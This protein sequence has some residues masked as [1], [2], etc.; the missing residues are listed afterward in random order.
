MMSAAT[1]TGKPKAGLEVV[2][3]CLRLHLQVL[4][5]VRAPTPTKGTERGMPVLRHE[6]NSGLHSAA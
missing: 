1:V 4:W 5:T 2:R 6:P 3:W